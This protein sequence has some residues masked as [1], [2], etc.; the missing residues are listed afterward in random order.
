MLR[1]NEVAHPVSNSFALDAVPH[2]ASRRS[3]RHTPPTPLRSGVPVLP[4]LRVVVVQRPDTQVLIEKVV[5]PASRSEGDPLDQK[6]RHAPAVHVNRL[7]E[8]AAGCEVEEG[9]SDVDVAR[10]LPR[11]VAAGGHARAADDE[12]HADVGLVGVLL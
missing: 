10:D 11:E 6:R 4:D 2:I 9:R 8:I 7:H 1:I 3:P 12:G 5:S